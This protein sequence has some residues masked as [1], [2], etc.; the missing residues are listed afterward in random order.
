MLS[1]DKL[2]NQKR[3]FTRLTGVKLEEFL[4]IV[5]K[6]RPG[7]E[8]LQQKKKVSGR[9]S[10]LKTLEDEMQIPVIGIF[11]KKITS[12]ASKIP[13]LLYDKTSVKSTS[14]SVDIQHFVQKNTRKIIF[15]NGACF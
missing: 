8:K 15:V 4:K 2:Y 9:N 13:P 7:W 10:H 5:E 3:N 1:L 12:K 14:A 6:V 11:R